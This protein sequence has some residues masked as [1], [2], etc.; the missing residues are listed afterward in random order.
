MT[1]GW[2]CCRKIRGRPPAS[3]HLLNAA[4]GACQD[5]PGAVGVLQLMPDGILPALRCLHFRIGI[6]G[7]DGGRGCLPHDYGELVQR[8]NKIL[9]NMLGCEID[10]II[11]GLEN[12]SRSVVASRKDAMYKKR[13]IFYMPDAAGNSRVC[14]DRIVQARVIAVA[15]K[16]VRVET[17]SFLPGIRLS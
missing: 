11:K 14:E 8:Q 7:K 1:A 16:V 13:Q 15:E 4:Q 17:S 5:L 12:A 10:F 6:Q 9:G 2:H 3:V